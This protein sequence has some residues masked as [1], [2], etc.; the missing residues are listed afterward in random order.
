ML[1]QK[2]VEDKCSEVDFL[3]ALLDGLEL[4]GAL[5]SLDALYARKEVVSLIYD[6]QADYLIALKGNQKRTHAIVREYFERT[7][8]G[9]NGAVLHPVFDA[10]DESHG[11]LTRRRAFVS[12]VSSLPDSLQNWKGAS[13]VIAVETITS[14]NHTYGGG[15]GKTT[16]DIRYFITSST[17][18]GS[19]LAA[20]VRNHWSIEN[21][22][23]WVLDMGFRED[24][25]RVRDKNA[26]SNLAAI[27]KIAMNLVKAESSVKG[28]IRG[29]RKA[30]G[31]DNDYMQKII[32]L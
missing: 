4:T 16:S 29:K 10:F 28:S 24:E 32:S 26:A 25:C 13:Q 21:S 22:L 5:I 12:D 2:V 8:F 31:W 27:R 18:A 6:K 15:R 23:H 9:G 3:P 11:R 17:Q 14:Q 30:A 20:A 1:A 7:A 19:V